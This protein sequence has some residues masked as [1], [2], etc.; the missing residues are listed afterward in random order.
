MYQRACG[1]LY[2]MKRLEAPRSESFN[3]R[4]RENKIGFISECHRL[5]TNVEQ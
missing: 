2:G 5:K 4:A 1:L 3:R